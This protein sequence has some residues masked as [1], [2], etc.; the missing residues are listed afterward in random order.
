ML[1]VWQAGGGRTNM[2]QAAGSVTG[3]YSNAGPNIIVAGSG[4]AVT[5]CLDVGG[6]TNTPGRF[7][8]IRL[9][10]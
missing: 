3:T 9:V 7:Y 6:A 4:D 10:P 8:R 1:I 5:N 2:L